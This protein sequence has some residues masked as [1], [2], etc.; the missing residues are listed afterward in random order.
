MSRRKYGWAVQSVSDTKTPC[1][2]HKHLLLFL[3][4]GNKVILWRPSSSWDQGCH[5]KVLYHLI[6][7]SYVMVPCKMW[8][9][10][11]IVYTSVWDRNVSLDVQPLPSSK[12]GPRVHWGY[13]SYSC[14]FV[15]SS[16]P[17]SSPSFHMYFHKRTRPFSWPKSLLPRN[18]LESIK[19]GAYS[20]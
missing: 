12:Q 19:L 18:G 15:V 1:P 3:T 9:V 11:I 10:I 17:I 20:W 14:L 8:N 4:P 6:E 5:C 2:R 7:Y 13:S 16:S